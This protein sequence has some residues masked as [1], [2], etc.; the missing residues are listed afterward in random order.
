M[1]NEAS[2]KKETNY[3]GRSTNISDFDLI[4]TENIPEN[5]ISDLDGVQKFLLKKINDQIYAIKHQPNAWE[6]EDISS[7]NHTALSWASLLAKRLA[8]VNIFDY[9]IKP[10]I[11]EGITLTF[12]HRSQ[13]LHFEAYN[14]GELGYII[15]D[16]KAKRIIDNREVNSIDEVTQRISRFLV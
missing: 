16:F 4:S 5:D 7:P 2:T 3:C 12:K 1:Y 15:E 9:S 8:Q 10:S 6:N 11:E 14:D 13:I